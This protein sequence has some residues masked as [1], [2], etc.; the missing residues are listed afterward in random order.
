MKGPKNVCVFASGSGTNL[1]SLIN[2]G[3]RK[4]ASFKISLVISDKKNSWSLVRAQRSKIPFHY[5][6]Y[7]EKDPDTFG[8]NSLKLLI[9]YDIDIVVLAGFLRFVPGIIL[10]EFK[11]RIINIHPALLPAFGGHGMYGV[12]VHRSVLQKGVRVTGVTVHFVTDEYDSGPI[13]AQ[14]PVFVKSDDTPDTLAKRVLK[15]EHSILKQA[16]KA[17]ALGALEVEAGKVALKGS[18]PGI[19]VL[20]FGG[21]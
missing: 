14:A 10:R 13:I 16:V 19:N 15:K 1:Q 17:L 2:A 9:N 4:G 8:N 18:C 21:P 6:K 20:Y 12:N 5:I 3:K 7:S 11:N